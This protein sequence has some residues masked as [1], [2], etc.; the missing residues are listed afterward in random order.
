MCDI[1]NTDERENT[2]LSEEILLILNSIKTH[3]DIKLPLVL[4][5]SLAIFTSCASA[6][7]TKAQSSCALLFFSSS[8]FSV[9]T[10]TSSPPSDPACCPGSAPHTVT[11]DLCNRKRSKQL[12]LHGQLV[13]TALL[14]CISLG[15]DTCL[16]D[17]P[18][19]HWAETHVHSQ[20]HPNCVHTKTLIQ[21][22][23]I[24]T[25]PQAQY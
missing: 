21:R 2:I 1:M 4:L 15:G 22:Y 6:L 9:S 23:N 17:C 7:H 5:N 16:S 25:D 19:G 24:K 11:F 10:H 14:I 20:F 8:F 3:N 13:F 18:R 12:W